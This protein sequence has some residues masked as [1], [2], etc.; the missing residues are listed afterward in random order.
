MNGEERRD[1]VLDYHET[2]NAAVLVRAK[3][4]FVSALLAKG[5]ATADDVYAAVDLPAGVNARC[6]GAVYKRFK[7]AGII[8]A[9]GVVESARPERHAGIIRR[10]ELVDRGGAERWLA[11]H[12]ERS[13]PAAHEKTRQLELPGVG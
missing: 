8:R 6:L 7:R 3:R 4:A 9:A 1:A 13:E 11:E 10:W 12:S 5:E 2:A